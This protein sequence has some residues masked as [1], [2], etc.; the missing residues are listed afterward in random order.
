MN[1]KEMVNQIISN[2]GGANNVSNVSHCMTRLR[3]VLKDE[4]KVDKKR[5]EEINGVI[6]STFGAGQYQIVLGKHLDGVFG[7]L[8]KNYDFGDETQQTSPNEKIKKPLN[9]KTIGKSI[10]DYMSGSVSPVITGLMAGGILK[11]FLYFATL[12]ISGVE[13]NSTYVLIS[14]IANTPFYFMPILV[15]YGASRKLDCSPVLPM[16][17]ACTLIDPSYIALEG[18]QKLFGLDVPLLGYST[19]VIP[20]M[21]S[22]LVV[23]NI[24]KFFNKVVPGIIKNVLALPLTFLVSFII[25]IVFLAPLG[26]YIGNYVVNGLVWLNSFAAPLSLGTLAAVLPFMIMAGVHTLVAP[27]MLENFSSL[28]FDPLF[29]PALLLQLLAVGGAAFGIAFRQREKA[30]RVDMISIG[31]SSVIAGITE[32]GIFGI[33]M[34][35]TSAMIGCS[36]GAFVGG[37]T[38]GLLGMKAFVMTKNTI[39]ALPVFQDTIIAAAIACFVT[40]TVSC[41]V[42]YLFYKDK[43]STD[44]KNI[45]NKKDIRP[46]VKGKKIALEEVNDQVFSKKMMGEGLAFIPE[47]NQIYAPFDGTIITIFPTNHAYGILRDDGLEAIIH[48][49]IDTASTDGEGFIS[50][51]KANDKVKA[52]DSIAEVD[53]EFLRNKG[54][55]VTTI[56]VFPELM[57]HDI[58]WTLSNEKSIAIV[59]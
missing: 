16:I 41:A 1:Y 42:T 18:P 30:K 46:V 12:L 24:E 31:V 36:V 2:I 15:A 40:I 23:Y 48:I 37:I 13:E 45:T 38:G 59:E 8:M 43:N 33:N 28:G 44:K 54:Y 29:R 19:T 21:L 7:E 10:V 55:D 5:I 11:L 35:Y 34:K 9:L 58:T 20:A 32:P 22:T 25:T 53:F 49:G 39:L 57:N 17:L 51:V 26:N 6:G 56:L 4:S 52:G 50:L 27:F 14:I 3:F 47:S